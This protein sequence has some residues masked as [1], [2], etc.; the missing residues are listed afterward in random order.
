MLLL[1]LA[2]NAI[3]RFPQNLEQPNQCQFKHPVTLEIGKSLVSNNR[4]R[5]IG[6]VKHLT[7]GKLIV[8]RHTASTSPAELALENMG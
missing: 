7:Q 6:V 2:T 3:R 4:L 1:L 8:M 5:L